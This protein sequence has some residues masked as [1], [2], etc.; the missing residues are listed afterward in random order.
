MLILKNFFIFIISVLIICLIIIIFD[1]LGIHKKFNV[2]FSAMLY[3]LIMTLY[4]KKVFLSLLFFFG[5]YS[6]L[7]IISYS[8]EVIGML[9]ISCSVLFLIK[10]VMPK[11]KNQEINRF[12]ISDKLYKE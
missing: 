5:F 2:F 10:I 3:G 12:F 4:L 11:L 8:I 1:K 7:F 9:L 6:L